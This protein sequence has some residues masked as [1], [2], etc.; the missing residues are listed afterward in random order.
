MRGR[1]FVYTGESNSCAS[2]DRIWGMIHSYDQEGEI[3]TSQIRGIIGELL[4]FKLHVLVSEVGGEFGISRGAVLITFFLALLAVLSHL[5]PNLP[6]FA[7]GWILGTAPIW[8][9]PAAVVIAWK[10]RLWYMR[11]KFLSTRKPILLEVKMPRALVK[12][13][14][15]METALTDLWIDSGET[16]F[17]HRVWLG[18][19]RP[20]FS[21]EI[22]SF[23]GE[24]HFYIWTWSAWR[25]TI[26]ST[27]YAQYPELE[28][29]EAE[30]YASKFSY[31]PD[32][33]LA[34]CTDW[35]YEPR[36][37]AY[38]IRTYV[39]FEL[40]K[41]PKEEYRVDP[42]AQ[43]LEFMSSL[44][45][46]EQA[47]LQIIITLGKDRQR[48]KGGRWFETEDRYVGTLQAEIEKIK[49]DLIGN[50]DDPKEK[51]KSYS[52]VQQHRVNETIR[53][54]ERNMGKHPFN[55]GSRGVYFA[56]PKTFN[57]PG[58]TGLRWIWRPMGNAQYL[59]QMR[60]RRWHNPFDYPYQDLWDLR[61]DLHTR[62]FFDAYRRRS[63]FY[64]PWVFPHNMMSTEVIASLWH[65]PTEAIK[66]PGLER[67][68]AKKA[69]PPPNLP[70]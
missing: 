17:Y 45:G 58:Y 69:E 25:G 12:S 23:G 41:D 60:P 51:W 40:D 8:I 9:L 66:A 37:D 18:Q 47:W 11:A 5:I 53:L 59:N 54:I 19:V 46:T 6:L 15:A 33:H 21:F 52:R 28:I 32:K 1:L 14:R 27:L 24:V 42:F 2:N 50:P 7:F 16:T 57:G 64:A 48:K 39:E 20:F 43:V 68:P 56:D 49:K 38:P 55:V 13:P 62:R 4:E 35:R 36:N 10:A 63:H 22:T 3:S 44:K 29:V 31:D 34:F 65:P 61:W 30:D 70:K 67:I 26:E